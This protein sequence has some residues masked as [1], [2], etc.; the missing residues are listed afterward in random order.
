MSEVAPHVQ[1]AIE[2][3]VVPTGRDLLEAREVILDELADGTT[4]HINDLTRSMNSRRSIGVPRYDEQLVIAYSDGAWPAP[5]GNEPPLVRKRVEYA[6]RESLAGLLREGLVVPTVGSAYGEGTDSITVHRTTGGSSTTGPVSFASRVVTFDLDRGNCR[7]RLAS[8]T[9][10]HRALLA[11]TDIADGLDD[12][13][14]ARGTE[15]LREAVRCFYQGRFLAAV[16]LLA[17]T[18]EAAWFG[19]ASAAAGRD[20]RLDTLVAQGEMVA[21]V[22]E[23]TTAVLASER[24]LAPATRNDVRAQAARYRD[25]RNYGLHP[26]GDRDADR[27]DSFSEPGA[28]ALFL[29]ARR[30]LLQLGEARTALLATGP[31]N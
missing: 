10:T 25:L 2:Q 17:A 21:T 13:L 31:S 6:V 22:I 3:F 27:E 28:A 18:S 8:P 26:V 20:A 23:R 14:G 16:D 12:L 9:A 11:R 24:I 5:T 15:V 29:T 19:V 1:E 30:Y 7:W 4:R